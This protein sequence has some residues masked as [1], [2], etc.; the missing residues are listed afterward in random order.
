VAEIEDYMFNKC[1]EIEHLTSRG[2]W[3]KSGLMF[4]FHESLKKIVDNMGVD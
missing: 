3:A 2:M 1:D 4:G